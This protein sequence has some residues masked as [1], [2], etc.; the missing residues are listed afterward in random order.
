MLFARERVVK[1]Q[2]FAFVVVQVVTNQLIEIGQKSLT[3]KVRTL[4]QSHWGKQKTPRE[5]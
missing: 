4:A 3:R 5:G 1:T 2:R